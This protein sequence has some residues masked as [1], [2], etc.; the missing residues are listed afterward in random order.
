MA[1]PDAGRAATAAIRPLVL[2]HLPAGIVAN[3]TLQER[4]RKEA[5]HSH[6][7]LTRTGGQIGGRVGISPARSQ[8]HLTPSGI[9]PATA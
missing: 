9:T 2:A 8:D 1:G 4:R 5:Q 6:R 3:L 7:A